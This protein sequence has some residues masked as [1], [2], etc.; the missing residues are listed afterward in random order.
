LNKGYGN[1]GGDINL[2]YLLEKLFNDTYGEGYPQA[3]KEIQTMA[4]KRLVQLSLDTHKTMKEILSIINRE[5]I[6]NA[7]SFPGVLDFIKTAPASELK[8]YVISF[9]K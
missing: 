2:R 3:R 7:L 8:D 9:V 1:L 5:M 4:R 6:I